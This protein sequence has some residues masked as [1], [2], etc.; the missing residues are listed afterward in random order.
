MEDDFWGQLGLQSLM[1]SMSLDPFLFGT[2]EIAKGLYFL[3][4]TE[5]ASTCCLGNEI[6]FFSVLTGLPARGKS[7]SLSLT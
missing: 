1:S 2:S 5:E 3:R 7:P 6:A 4:F